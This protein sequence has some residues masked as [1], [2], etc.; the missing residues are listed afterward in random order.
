MQN[1]ISESQAR[2]IT[3]GRKPL[4]PVVYEDAVKAL[5]ECLSLD[6][7][8]HW[9][10]KADALAAWAKIYR[11]DK[12][13]RQAKALKLHAYR[14]LGELAREVRPQKFGYRSD[15]RFSGKKNGPASLLKENGFSET[16][17][18]AIGYVSRLPKD[19]FEELTSKDKPPSPVAVWRSQFTSNQW[20]NVRASASS[21]RTFCRKTKASDAASQINNP[22]EVETARA[23][24]LELIEWLDEFERHLK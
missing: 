12:V 19:K 9:D 18:A 15:G 2:K 11:D 3:G 22:K 24:A 23:L 20:F 10:N 6:E 5:A 16:H 4:V 8:K 1:V 13:T 21:L 14:R 17:T 7:A